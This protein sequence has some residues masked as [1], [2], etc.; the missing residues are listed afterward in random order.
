MLSFVRVALVMC[1]FTAMETL[2]KTGYD[3]VYP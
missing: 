1:L 2:T 3:L